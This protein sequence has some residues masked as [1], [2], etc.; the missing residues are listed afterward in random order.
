MIAPAPAREI[1]KQLKN[2]GFTSRDGK[3]S[4][5]MWTCAHGKVE[6]SVTTGHRT[7]SPG[8]R[9]QVDNAISQCKT[10]CK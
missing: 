6:V 1:I 10:N 5:T 7:I 8:V 2:A 4:H 3:G 9:R